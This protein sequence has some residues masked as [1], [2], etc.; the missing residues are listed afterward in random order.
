MSTEDLEARIKVLEDINAIN[1]LKARLCFMVD[2]GNWVG[3][4]FVED[5]VADFGSFGLYEG[6]TA[7]AQFYHDV[8]KT[9]P[10]T[11]HM[12]HNTCI[13]VKGDEASAEWYFQVPATHAKTNRA[14][15]IH[16]KYMDEF[17]KV[18]SEWKFKK[19]KGDAYHYTPFDEGWVKTKFYE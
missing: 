18:G 5:A 8:S 15:W 1:I 19:T 6:K 2:T 14:V 12:I 17:V 9:L 7:I 16:G 3:E 13:E 10:G 11:M 4:L